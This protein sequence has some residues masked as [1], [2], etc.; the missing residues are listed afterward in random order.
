MSDIPGWPASADPDRG[1]VP[2]YLERYYW[3]A[4]LRPASLRFFDRR[5]VVSAILWGQYRRLGNI[6]LAGIAPGSRVLQLACVYGDLS[7]RL[8]GQ[9]GAD[10]LLD[11]VDI[12]PIQVRHARAKLAAHPRAT[13]RVADAAEPGADR[14]DTVLCFF[15]LHELP[16]RHKRRVVDAALSRLA[17]DGR[18]VFIDYARPAAAHPLRPVMA[19]VF[20]LLEPFARTM[21]HHEIASLASDPASHDWSRRSIFG[22]LY[23]TVVATRRAAVATTPSIR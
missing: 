15:L 8:A 17:P 3:W 21:W 1:A 12:A 9:V 2:D 22:G 19:T 18:A 11:I 13:V 16:D 7:A 6:A 23:Q 14:Y 5:A 10:G 20:A 4:Y